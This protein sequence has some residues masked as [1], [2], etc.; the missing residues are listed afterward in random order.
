MVGNVPGNPIG[1]QQKLRAV[2][3]LD[4]LHVHFD[5]VFSAKGATDNVLAGMIGRLFRSHPPSAHFFF[6]H[7]MVCRLAK[8]FFAAAVTFK[9]RFRSCV[10]A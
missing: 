2:V 6:D 1:A 5:V 10:P 3:N 8:K 4:Y 7:R 9:R